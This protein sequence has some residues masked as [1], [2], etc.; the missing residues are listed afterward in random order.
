MP[1]ITEQLTQLDQR[2]SYLEETTA[3]LRQQMA[4]LDRSSHAYLRLSDLLRMGEDTVAKLRA[5]RHAMAL[6]SES[7]V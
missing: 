7:D 1:S 3:D 6:R 5:Q 4:D 2:I